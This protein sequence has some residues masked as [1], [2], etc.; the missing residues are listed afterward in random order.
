MI[1]ALDQ[2]ST[3]EISF[4]GESLE[5]ADLDRLRAK[6]IGFVFQSFYLLPNLTAE[7]NVQIPMFEGD[8][9]RPDRRERARQLLDQVGLQ[10]RM[11]HL[12][13]RLSIGERQRVAIARAL[14]NQPSVILADEPTGAL[15]SQSGNEVM[16]LLSDFTPTT[17]NYVGCSNSRSDN[18]RSCCKDRSIGRWS[19]GLTITSVIEATWRCRCESRLVFP[20]AC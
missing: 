5:H 12:P 18:R 2:P 20:R 4:R 9:S 19:G 17:W 13:G 3:G 7:E 11:K 14:A 1:G 16:D 6:E 8:H 15:D 10:K